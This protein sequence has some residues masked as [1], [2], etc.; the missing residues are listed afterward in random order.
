MLFTQ[1]PHLCYQQSFNS[2]A[3]VK[4][5]ELWNHWK[6]TTEAAAMFI[7]LYPFSPHIPSLFYTEM[8]ASKASLLKSLLFL[9]SLSLIQ[10]LSIQQKVR[11][12]GIVVPGTN[13][14]K[15][16]CRS[17][18]LMIYI[19]M[20]G[21]I[22]HRAHRHGCQNKF[23]SRRGWHKWFKVKCFFFF[24]SLRACWFSP[25]RLWLCTW[26]FWNWMGTRGPVWK[27]CVQNKACVRL[28]PHTNCYL[29]DECEYLMH[30][31]DWARVL[32]V[33]WWGGIRNKIQLQI[34]DRVFIFT[35]DRASC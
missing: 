19:H 22:T 24:N 30:T 7:S 31:S 18:S 28:L 2:A 9:L 35:V 1:S 20:G 3:T 16:Y 5:Q 13:I 25:C 23:I 4:F 32:L 27:P 8:F 15:Y 14:D 12:K 21:Y 10:A 33:T 26:W 29:K 6:F 11:Q 34:T 17:I